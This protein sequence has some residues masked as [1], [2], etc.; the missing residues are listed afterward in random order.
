[1]NHSRQSESNETFRGEA[2]SASRKDVEQRG[3]ASRAAGSAKNESEQDAVGVAQEQVEKVVTMARDQ[4]MSQLSSRKERAAGSLSILS[5]SLRDASQKM[6]DQDDDV[7]AGY[8]ETTADQIDH[9][10]EMLKEQ[11]IDG[12]LA[13]AQQFARRQPALFLAAAFA[14]GFAGTRFLKASSPAGATANGY[15]SSQ[16]Q[17]SWQEGRTAASSATSAGRASQSFDRTTGVGGQSSFTGSSGSRPQSD[18]ATRT[19]VNPGLGG[20]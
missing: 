7:I 17:F 15:G 6:R 2:T 4:A 10:S 18:W 19:G 9:L 13:T 20:Q 8:V 5:S 3:G 16:G 11:D 1:M 14:L 12:L